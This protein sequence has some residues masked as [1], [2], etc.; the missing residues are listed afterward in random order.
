MKKILTMLL[1]VFFLSII[2]MYALVIGNIPKEI[3]VFEGEEISMRTLLGIS[4]KDE[5]LGAIYYEELSSS[6]YET[7]KLI[8][9]E[10]G[11]PALLLHNCH[12]ISKDDF[13][14]GET[15]IS[16]M[17]K[18]LENLNSGMK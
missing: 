2:Y 15:Y 17:Y 9:K 8:E 16:L 6:S 5:N 13:E 10:A 4:I 11:V 1:L 14:N 12:N 18:N 3:V 7:A